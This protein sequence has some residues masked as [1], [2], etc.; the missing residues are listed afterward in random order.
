MLRG[1]D[2]KALH[3]LGQRLLVRS[4]DQQMNMRSLNT[5]MYDANAAAHR[6]RQG[7]L[8]DRMVRRSAA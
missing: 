7:G 8:T 6:R 4:L 1:G 3:A 5:E 2:L